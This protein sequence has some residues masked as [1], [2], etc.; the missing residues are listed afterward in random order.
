[1]DQRS[2]EGSTVKIN[3]ILSI[4]EELVA[5]IDDNRGKMTRSQFIEA[6]L[7]SMQDERETRRDAPRPRRDEGYSSREDVTAFRRRVGS[8]LDDLS[9]DS[10]DA[11]RRATRR[12]RDGPDDDHG[13]GEG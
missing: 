1:M 8:M 5:T 12:R 13:R 7:S 9:D 6:C 2:R 3:I 4:D 11:E 10:P